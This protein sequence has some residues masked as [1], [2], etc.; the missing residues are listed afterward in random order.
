MLEQRF[1]ERVIRG[2]IGHAALSSAAE[3]IASRR[4]DPYA[5][6]NEIL[7]RSWHGGIEV[8]LGDLEFWILNDG[9]FRLDGGAMF[10]VIPKPLWEKKI[11]ADE[12]N[13]IGLEMNCLLVRAAGKTI[14]VETG[15]GDKMGCKTPRHLCHSALASACRSNSRRAALV[16]IR[17]ITS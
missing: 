12:R 4:K 15:A 5:V 3:E 10:G 13:R 1:A 14:L 2:R 11:P 7:D 9:G 16:S 17:L 6:V 8:K